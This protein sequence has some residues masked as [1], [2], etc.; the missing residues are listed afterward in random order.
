[1]LP[2]LQIIVRNMV[3]AVILEGVKRGPCQMAGYVSGGPATKKLELSGGSDSGVGRVAGNPSSS[4]ELGTSVLNVFCKNHIELS[5]NL[6]D[7]T[8]DLQVAPVGMI[9]GKSRCHDSPRRVARQERR[10]VS[11]ILLSVI[12]W[13]AA[14]DAALGDKTRSLMVL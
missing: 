4:H 12:A 2:S 14:C 1:M 9:G 6:P 5:R 3:A 11:G 10:R 13:I 8:I 7:Y